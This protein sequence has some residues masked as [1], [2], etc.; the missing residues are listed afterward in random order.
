M[1]STTWFEGIGLTVCHEEL[2][3]SHHESVVLVSAIWV[4]IISNF[5]VILVILIHASTAHIDLFFYRY[6]SSRPKCF[7]NYI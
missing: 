5:G 1:V 4:R 6:L 2:Q 7:N 3:K